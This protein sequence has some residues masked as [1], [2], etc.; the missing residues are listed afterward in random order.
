[1]DVSTLLWQELSRF[2]EAFPCEVVEAASPLGDASDGWLST[3]T[4]VAV[5]RAESSVFLL[6]LHDFLL[7][8]EAVYCNPMTLLEGHLRRGHI[9]AIPKSAAARGGVILRLLPPKRSKQCVVL[10]LNSHPIPTCAAT[11]VLLL[12]TAL[13]QLTGDS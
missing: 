13:R 5:A 8:S 12:L 4:S 10:R 9:L 11:R 2:F 6:L 1:V 7:T 3:T